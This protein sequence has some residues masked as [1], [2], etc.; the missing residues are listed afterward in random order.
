MSSNQNWRYVSAEKARLSK[1]MD[2]DQV[3]P[4]D[5][6]IAAIDG[7]GE[8]PEALFEAHTFIDEILTAREAIIVKEIV[9]NK[10][11]FQATANKMGLK[12]DNTYRIYKV[13]LLKL[14]GCI[15]I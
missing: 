10:A 3:S 11:T 14:K 6:W 12:K 13:A 1:I 15:E 4:E 7:E 5:S 8:G 2:Y 9:F